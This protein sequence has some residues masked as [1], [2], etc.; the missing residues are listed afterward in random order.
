VLAK[1]R[2]VAS[3]PFGTGPEPGVELGA[4]DVAWLD[5][6]AVL[7]G[8]VLVAA[9]VVGGGVVSKLDVPAECVFGCCRLATRTIDATTPATHA[10]ATAGSDQ[11]RNRERAL[12]RA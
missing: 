4:L 3:K 1:V 9:A 8:A 11:A 5:D 12:R 10:A 2:S 7:A 6:A